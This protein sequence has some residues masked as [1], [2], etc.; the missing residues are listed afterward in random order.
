M[1]E[2]TVMADG[3]DVKP[4]AQPARTAPENAVSFE[5]W[6]DAVVT[7]ASSM[8]AAPEASFVAANATSGRPLCGDAAAAAVAAPL[9]GVTGL[10]AP[11]ATPATTSGRRDAIPLVAVR[12]SLEEA[13]FLKH[14]LGALRVFEPAA[15]GTAS[16]VGQ[17]S[18]QGQGAATTAAEEGQGT[19]MVVERDD[20]GGPA[21][22]GASSSSTSDLVELDEPRLWSRFCAIRSS[23][24]T[25]Y[26][27]YH[28]M[29]AKV[30]AQLPGREQLVVIKCASAPTATI[31]RG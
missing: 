29:K 10:V 2:H 31:T 1:A 14:V 26:V 19:R 16:S 12:L 3:S 25:N 22:G 4:D 5:S 11:A 21:A 9:S 7:V 24:V 6:Q 20:D 17:D 23:F 30:G 15:A 18:G 27:G 13:F 8:A 28:H